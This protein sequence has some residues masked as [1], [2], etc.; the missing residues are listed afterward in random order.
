MKKVITPVLL[1]AIVLVLC[2]CES[3]EPSLHHNKTIFTTKGYTSFDLQLIVPP[4]DI[5]QWHRITIFIFDSAER[6]SIT[7]SISIPSSSPAQTHETIYN[8]PV[9]LRPGSKVYLTFD[10][11]SKGTPMGHS[12]RDL[13]NKGRNGNSHILFYPTTP[14]SVPPT[15]SKTIT[16]NLSPTY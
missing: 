4:T 7:C 5:I 6:E 15:P 14:L 12:G 16:I 1:L 3:E 13:D 11:E 2:G 8:F 10:F 9:R